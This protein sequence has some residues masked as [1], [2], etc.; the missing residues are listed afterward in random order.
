MESAPIECSIDGSD[1]EMVALM[2][3]QGTLGGVHATA[4][5]SH[6]EGKASHI[7]LD[8]QLQEAK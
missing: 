8:V 4:C 6:A 1:A 2:P 3:A 5:P 7:A